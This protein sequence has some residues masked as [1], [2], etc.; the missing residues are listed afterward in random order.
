MRKKE[1]NFDLFSF[2]NEVDEVLKQLLNA[3]FSDD[4]ETVQ[5]LS[6]DTALGLLSGSLKARKEMVSLNLLS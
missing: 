6:G 4:L 3:Y 2:E 5:K 1:P